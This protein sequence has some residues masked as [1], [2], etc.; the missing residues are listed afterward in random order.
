M[1]PPHSSNFLPSLVVRQPPRSEPPRRLETTRT[2]GFHMQEYLLPNDT[3]LV[4]WLDS[5]PFHALDECRCLE[6]YMVGDHATFAS[7]GCSRCPVGGACCLCTSQSPQNESAALA[8]TGKPCQMCL[9]GLR[10]RAVPLPGFVEV[11]R[12]ANASANYTADQNWLIV[13]CHVPEACAGGTMSAPCTAG[14][15]GPRCMRLPCFIAA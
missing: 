9:S 8:T 13:P 4:A 7:R 5:N 12:M 10:D 15:T 6:N 1:C 3:T 14:Y 11:S 2:A